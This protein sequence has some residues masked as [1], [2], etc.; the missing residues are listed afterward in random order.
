MRHSRGLPALE[1]SDT[2]RALAGCRGA[3]AK[4]RL[5]WCM[6]G[7]PGAD[8]Q[9]DLM[10]IERAVLEARQRF[11]LSG[12]YYDP[13]QAALMAQ[14]L[15]RQGVRMHEVPFVGKNL[16]E[17]AWTLLQLFASYEIE[18]YRSPLDSSKDLVR[19]L[20]RL[21]IVER[22][23]GY[24][25]ES[26]RDETG[27]ADLAVALAIALPRARR[28]A[29]TALLAQCCPTSMV[30]PRKQPAESGIQLDGALGR[31]YCRMGR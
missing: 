2:S 14:R 12:V 28:Q 18:L 27:H 15:S 10:A 4:V 23:F 21:T 9:I 31:S 8:G 17:M 20:G 1:C 19:D 16:S 5:A 11:R 26:A 3:Q 13:T 30:M 6:S 22:P 29:G 25:L 7:A 24:K